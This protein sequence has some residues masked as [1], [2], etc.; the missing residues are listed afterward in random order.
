MLHI[1]GTSTLLVGIIYKLTDLLFIY[2]VT[3]ILH[4]IFD[5]TYIVA[6]VLR[7]QYCFYELCISSAGIVLSIYF[8]LVVFLFRRKCLWEKS[9]NYDQ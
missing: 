9:P 3:N 4:M 6:W 7:C 5:T 1:V 2:L 8:W